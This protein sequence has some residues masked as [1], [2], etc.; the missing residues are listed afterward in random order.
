MELWA[1]V[2]I[3]NAS[4]GTRACFVNATETSPLISINFRNFDFKVHLNT[5]HEL[6]LCCVYDYDNCFPGVSACISL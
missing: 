4:A 6:E 5:S 3:A 1:D 2:C